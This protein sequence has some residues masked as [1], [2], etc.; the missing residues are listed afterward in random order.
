LA[1]SLLTLIVVLAAVLA[2]C[3]PSGLSHRNA[4]Y[5]AGRKAV[6]AGDYKSAEIRFL[7][8]IQADKRFGDGYLQL[9]DVYV[10]TGQPLKAYEQL[11]RAGEL[12][13]DRPEVAE[14]L[15]EFTY[16]IYFADP[17]RPAAVLREVE[18]LSDTLRTKWPQRPAGYRLAGQ[19]LMERHRSDE[20]IAVM[21]Q[22]LAHLEDGPLRTQLAA[23]YYQAGD[24][25]KAEEHLRECIRANPK[26][27][28]GFDLLY[29]QLMEHGEVTKARLVLADKV[30]IQGGVDPSLQLAAHD[31]AAG[32]RHQAEQRLVQLSEDYAEDSLVPAKIGDF[33]LHRG[34]LTKAREWYET[35][36]QKFPKERG[37]YAGRKAE[38]L[39]AEK[40]PEGAKALVAEE[41]LAHPGDALLR[42]YQAAFGLDGQSEKERRHVQAELESVLAQMPNSPFVRLHLG[43]AYLLNGDLLRAGE[44]L[45][46]TV[47]LDPNYAPGWLALAELELATGD[48]GLA[49]D[50]LAALLRRAPGYLPAQ[51]VK[52]QANLAQHKPAE[53][54]KTLTSLLD[55]D[56][57]NI[58]VML[59]LARARV[60]LGNNADA[61][62]LLER[63]H[64]L[65][66]S[67]PRP[68]LLLARL[69]VARGDAKSALKRLES[70]G[71]A[72]SEAPEIES[73]TGSVAL[74]AAQNETARMKFQALVAKDPENLQYRLGFATS[75]AM[76]GQT[77][78]AKEQYLAVQKKAGSNPQP[79]LL[80]GVM[81]SSSG[82]TAAAADAYRE[83]L[84][85]DAKN[86]FALNNLAFLMA[87]E[88]KDMDRALALAEEARRGMPRSREIHDTLAYIYVRLGMKRNATAA[89]EELAVT[90]PASQQ[91]RTRALVEEI[92][93]GNLVTVREEME[94]AS[95]GLN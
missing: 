67:D 69:D 43:R 32:S 9:A 24:K 10:A 51:L 47:N 28:P 59:A 75:L 85:R 94:R 84:K 23:A 7:R 5:E 36:L 57:E 38:L 70:V 37:V 13:P 72:L 35:G 29:L 48:A 60:S 93:R 49:Q 22:A 58:E 83:A 54:E 76:L 17:G 91:Q 68:V 20:A 80:Y 81:M 18:H 6:A 8:A 33:W 26:Y 1:H 74:L 14:R 41:L 25:V 46:S 56:P 4:D 50:Q 71:G 2:G 87:R 65:R 12:L 15:G 19:V 31:D 73:L 61:V 30:R 39:M 82:N 40:N 44:Q 21:E 92:N 3:K 16:Q 90:Q 64:S 34:E 77:E 55:A 78:K 27:S 89:L 11:V 52:A 88:G 66:P 45:R 62:R 42:A 79:W 86:P 53:A 63:S 95:A